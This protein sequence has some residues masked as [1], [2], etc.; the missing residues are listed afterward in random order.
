MRV[1]NL[2]LLGGDV[3]VAGDEDRH[4]TADSL[5]TLREASNV[6]EEEL[7]S[8]SVTTDDTTLNG[9]TI[10]DSLVGVNTAVG[11]LDGGEKGVRRRRIK[12]GEEVR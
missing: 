5:N 7:L 9:S 1:A 10:G 12:R 4:D 11:L 6:D 3:G 2:R 8:T